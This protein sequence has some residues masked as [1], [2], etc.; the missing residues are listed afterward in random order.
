MKL[1]LR[2]EKERST[3]SIPNSDGSAPDNSLPEMSK[4]CKEFNRPSSDDKVESKL[5]FGNEKEWSS[6]RIPNSDGSAPD[7]EL[8]D[9]SKDCKEVKS[10]SSDGKGPNTLL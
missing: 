4:D 7:K 1:L 8:S 10:P 5:L 9:M 3:V 2:N 6:V